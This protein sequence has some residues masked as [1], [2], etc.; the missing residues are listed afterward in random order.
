MYHDF[1]AFVHLRYGRS[2][3][4]DLAFVFFPAG[5]EA[6]TLELRAEL[7]AGGAVE[8]LVTGRTLSVEPNGGRRRLSVTAGPMRLAILAEK[9]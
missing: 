6:T 4:R 9:K 5:I 7:F 1:D 3:S 2:G 8:E